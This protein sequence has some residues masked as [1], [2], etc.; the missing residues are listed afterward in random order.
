MSTPFVSPETIQKREQ[1]AEATLDRRAYR[2][3]VACGI[4]G[5]LIALS[6]L[7]AAIWIGVATSDPG[8]TDYAGIVFMT[9]MIG[10]IVGGGGLIASVALALNYWR[11]NGHE[12]P[13]RR[14]L[15]LRREVEYFMAEDASRYLRAQGFDVPE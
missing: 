7:A 2:T 10:F 15:R 8:G 13:G 11:D 6:G 1:L 3:W 14:V 9:F 5:L 12:S 4:I